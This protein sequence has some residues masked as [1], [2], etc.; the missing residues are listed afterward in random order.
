MLAPALLVLGGLFLGGLGVVVVRSLG[1]QP[2]VGLT[3]PTLDAYRA[4]LGSPDF[5]GSLGLSLWIAGASTA[6]SVALGIGAAML[7]QG[8]G[9]GRAAG[10]FLFQL[11]LTVPHVVGAIGIGWLLAQSGLVARAAHALGLIDAPADFPALTQDRRAV[12][13]ILLYVWKEVPFVGLLVLAQLSSLGPDP[14][15]AA[16]S[17]G[18]TRGQAFRHVTLPL[19]L[20]AAAAGGA[21]TFAFAL[22]AYEGPLLLGQSYPQALAVL[23]WRHATAV[24][25]ATRPEAAAMAVVIAA[26]AGAAVAAAAALARPGALRR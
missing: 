11:N 18:A 12:G 20:P 13:V 23:A 22:G 7:L 1:I 15:A 10:R 17:H 3:E 4:V 26:V 2:A 8:A 19:I 9:A 25:I 24:D 21:V 6:L 5:L 14:A 16:R